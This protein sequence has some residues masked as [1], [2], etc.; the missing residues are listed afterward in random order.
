[1]HAN[2]LRMG[3]KKVA[4]DFSVSPRDGTRGNGH[5]LNHRKFQ[6]NMMNI[7]TVRVTEHWNWLPIEAMESPSLEIFQMSLDT[8]LYNLL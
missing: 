1:M 3:V 8:I 5:K 6:L 4:P 7:F 2:M